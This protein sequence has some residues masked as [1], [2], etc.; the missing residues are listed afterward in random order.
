MV[1]H[2]Y[3]LMTVCPQLISTVTWFIMLL[4][5]L[6]SHIHMYLPIQL[7]V[8]FSCQTW[9]NKYERKII[10]LYIYVTSIW[11]QLL[12]T[13]IWCWQLPSQ[14]HYFWPMADGQLMYCYHSDVNS[15]F[16]AHWD[17]ICSKLNLNNIYLY[18]HFI[19]WIS[20]IQLKHI[21]LD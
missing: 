19:N 20:Y 3:F 18:L 11:C 21:W 12:L 9:W 8:N 5:T 14:K 7:D 17:P 6:P 15:T 13:S 4:Y 1:Q 2:Y 10:F 16:F